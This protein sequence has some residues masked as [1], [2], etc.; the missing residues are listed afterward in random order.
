MNWPKPPLEFC[1]SDGHF[2]WAEWHALWLGIGEGLNPLPC[3]EPSGVGTKELIEH[4]RWYYIVGRGVG[5]IGLLV[6]IAVLIRFAR[7]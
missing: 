4:D 6:L 3:R 1:W 2:D 5:F 7:G